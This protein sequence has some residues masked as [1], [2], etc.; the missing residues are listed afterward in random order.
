MTLASSAHQRELRMYSRTTPRPVSWYRSRAVASPHTGR[1]R[2]TRAFWS[3][4]KHAMFRSVG[5]AGLVFVTAVRA[6]WFR[7][8]SSMDRNHS[9]SP[10]TATFSFAAHNRFGMSSSICE[11]LP[12]SISDA[13]DSILHNPSCGVH[14]GAYQPTAG[15]CLW[16]QVED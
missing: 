16:L 14:K 7:G 12:E 15:G 4:P 10:P 9:I 11:A 5:R 6:V 2:P 3:W 1:P 13:V 8:R